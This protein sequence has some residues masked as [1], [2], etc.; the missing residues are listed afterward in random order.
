MK[1]QLLLAI[2]GIGA[3]ASSSAQLVLDT[4]ST[5]AT[6]SHHCF[7][8]LGT[9]DTTQVARADWDLAFEVTG[10]GSGI[11][12]NGT[13][14]HTLYQ[15]PNGGV[16]DWTTLDTTGMSTTWP[17]HFDSDTSWSIGAFNRTTDNNFDV[18]WG[19]Y[20]MVNH[21]VVGDS[22]YVIKLSNSS[23]KK[24]WIQSLAG[25]SYTFRH[26]DLDNQ[27]DTTQT[28]VK[29]N[30][31]D[32]YFAYYSFDLLSARALGPVKTEWDLVFTSY[33]TE[34]QPGMSYGVSGVLTNPALQA[35]EVSNVDPLT[36]D[37][38]TATFTSNISTIGYDWK[39]F[40]MQTFTYDIQDSLVYF[41]QDQASNVWRIVFTGF[42]GSSTGNFYFGTSLVPLAQ[43][44][45]VAQTAQLTTYPNPSQ[46]GTTQLIVS[47]KENLQ[48]AQVSLFDMQG[49]MVQQGAPFNMQPGLHQF[50]LS[51]EGLNSGVYLLR[52][53]HKAGSTQTRVVVAQ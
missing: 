3:W 11:R 44:G 17:T 22:I 13:L 28:V 21:S 5:R 29:S 7:Y 37:W 25:G 26:A 30:F 40:N 38:T 4:A 34:L 20:N 31:P 47:T 49:R 16:N 45:P 2:I 9:G 48:D 18:G 35:A 1:R 33:L 50:P 27:N 19:T 53:S 43:E 10:Q 8:Q 14:G 42:G 15:Y 24:I 36:A 52:L 23:Y 41:V 39:S 6:Y 12:L 46:G 32:Q 51:L